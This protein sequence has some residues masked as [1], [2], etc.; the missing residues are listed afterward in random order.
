MLLQ[1]KL[2]KHGQDELWFFPR[3]DTNWN[4]K[5]AKNAQKN[6]K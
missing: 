5:N 1:M 2:C 6:A 4:K 3:L